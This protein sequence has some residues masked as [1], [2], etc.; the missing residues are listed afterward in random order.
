MPLHDFAC[1]SVCVVGGVE[2]CLGSVSA[3]LFFTE[4][5]FF[6]LV[7]MGILQVADNLEGENSM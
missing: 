5:L 4:V 2:F 7:K 6:F 3:V 1:V